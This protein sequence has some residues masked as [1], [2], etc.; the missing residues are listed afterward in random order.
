MFNFFKE[1]PRLA[2]WCLIFFI[3]PVL[4]CL[5]LIKGQLFAKL[6]FQNFE[7][8]QSTSTPTVTSLDPLTRINSVWLDGKLKIQSY[9]VVIFNFNK[10]VI[11]EIP[12][13]LP[14]Q[15]DPEVGSMEVSFMQA[16]HTTSTPIYTPVNSFRFGKIYS[17]T[18]TSIKVPIAFRF[19]KEIPLAVVKPDKEND[20]LKIGASVYIDASNS[21]GF[22]FPLLSD[23]G[24]NFA[25]VFFSWLIGVNAVLES[26]KFS[27]RKR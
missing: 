10:V 14:Y 27:R 22:A 12:V 18:L 5:F 13:Q 16:D 25:L 21:F 8:V 11:N 9:H 1:R 15:P 4:I 17:D 2:E 3:P 6:S 23:L 7:E 26:I 20:P 24:F 19:P